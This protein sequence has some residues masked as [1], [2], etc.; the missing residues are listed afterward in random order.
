[1]SGER[2][3]GGGMAEACALGVPSS[4]GHQSSVHTVPSEWES[5]S[6]RARMGEGGTQSPVPLS[7]MQRNT[8]VMPLSTVNKNTSDGGRRETKE[9]HVYSCNVC[10]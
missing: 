5:D 2:A 8:T 3:R 6:G 7:L 1:M 10:M 4:G 9:R